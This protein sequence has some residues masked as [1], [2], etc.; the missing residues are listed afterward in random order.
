M[1]MNTLQ[2]LCALARRD[3]DRAAAQLSAALRQLA[4]VQQIQHQLQSFGTEYRA[5]AV[6]A[7]VGAG[8]VGFATDAL[9]FGQR[10]HG[11]AMEQE[12][13]VA[14]HGQRCAFARDALAQAR[15]RSDGLQALWKQAQRSE[16]LALI[17][18]EEHGFDELAAARWV[19]R[20]GT[21]RATQY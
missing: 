16:R 3:E 18:R 11:T 5:A 10:L 6:N 12:A 20:V 2:A 17:R 15:L 13:R 4:R 21:E 1:Q 14:E 19:R 9:A 8:V 7:Q